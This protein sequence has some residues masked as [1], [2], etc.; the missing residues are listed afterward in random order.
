MIGNVGK[1]NGKEVRSFIDR[2][3]RHHLSPQGCNFAFGVKL[4]NELIGVITAGRPVAKALDDGNT[5]EVTR[6]CVKAG[7]KNLCSFLYSRMVKIAKDMNYQRVIT[8]T[9]ESETGSSC[10]AAGFKLAYKSKGGD[11]NCKSRPRHT[12][13]PTCPKSMW[14]YVIAS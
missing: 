4:G 6:V 7:Y 10:V 9:L 2:N 5:L 8:Y 1:K 3:H 14:E 11:W 12:T 13:S